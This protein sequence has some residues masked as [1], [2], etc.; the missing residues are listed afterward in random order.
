MVCVFVCVRA[1]ERVCVCVRVYVCMC[2]CMCVLAYVYAY[3]HMN[4]CV[5]MFEAYYVQILFEKD[6]TPTNLCGIS[7]G[8]VNT[9]ASILLF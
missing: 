8:R 1:R 3:F 2:E 7:G 6:L 9:Y 4:M 5:Y